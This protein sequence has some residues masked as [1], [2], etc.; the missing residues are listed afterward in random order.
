MFM[1]HHQA[2]A[3]WERVASSHCVGS[4]VAMEA[5]HETRVF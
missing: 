3:A 5:C 2:V 4:V 1:E